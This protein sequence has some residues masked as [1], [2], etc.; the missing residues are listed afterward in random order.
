M[1]EVEDFFSRWGRGGWEWGGIFTKEEKYL[2]KVE[3]YFL[4]NGTLVNL[5]KEFIEKNCKNSW[6]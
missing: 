3:F 6:K 1:T 5:A 4:L 2:W